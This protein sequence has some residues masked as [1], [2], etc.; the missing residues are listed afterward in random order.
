MFSGFKEWNSSQIRGEKVI[1]SATGQGAVDEKKTAIAFLRSVVTALKGLGVAEVA[2]GFDSVAS[3]ASSSAEHSAASVAAEPVV[4]ADDL[5][6]KRVS[7]LGKDF[8]AAMSGER[9]TDFKS[10]KDSCTRLMLFTKKCAALEQEITSS[11]LSTQL[12]I[13]RRKV[14]NDVG[15]AKEVLSQKVT[16]YIGRLVHHRDPNLEEMKALR[17]L[18]GTIQ[19]VL[20]DSIGG[21]IKIPDMVLEPL[22]TL[23][24][25]GVI[26][27]VERKW[28][29]ITVE[30]EQLE[31]TIATF[32][33]IPS[34]AGTLAGKIR[35]FDSKK[36]EF[37]TTVDS[38]TAKVLDEFNRLHDLIL[39]ADDRGVD[40]LKSK[41]EHL[42]QKC[43]YLPARLAAL[44]IFMSKAL[45]DMT[46]AALRRPL[47]AAAVNESQMVLRRTDSERHFNAL[48]L[49]TGGSPRS[50]EDAFL[51]ARLLADT[52]RDGKLVL[53]E[54]LGKF[55]AQLN[56]PR[57]ERLLT[58]LDINGFSFTPPQLRALLSRF[59]EGLGAIP[60]AANQAY[61]EFLALP[62][63]RQARLLMGTMEH[64][65][66][67][68]LGGQ[69]SEGHGPLM[70]EDSGGP[71]E[72]LEES[73]IG[74]AAPIVP[75]TPAAENRVE[76][77]A[78]PLSDRG[79]E[80]ASS[81]L[82]YAES[83]PPRIVKLEP[84]RMT[85]AVPIMGA[86]DI[87]G[88]RVGSGAAVQVEGDSDEEVDPQLA[89]AK[90]RLASLFAVD[91]EQLQKMKLEDFGAGEADNRIAKNLEVRQKA[92]SAIIPIEAELAAELSTATIAELKKMNTDL[93]ILDSALTQDMRDLS[94]DNRA[95]YQTLK[96]NVGIQTRLLI[97]TLTSLLKLADPRTF[98]KSVHT[99][100]ESGQLGAY[101][102]IAEGRERLVAKQAL[103]ERFTAES[104]RFGI[105][106]DAGVAEA[107][108]ELGTGIA[109]SATYLT[110]HEEKVNTINAK[111]A[112]IEAIV[113]NA[114]PQSLEAL[115]EQKAALGPL[116]TLQ[117]T[118]IPQQD[119]KAI[120][121]RLA[122]LKPGV[123]ARLAGLTKAID[124]HTGLQD[125]V[126]A[127][128]KR[129]ENLKRDVTA[130]PAGYKTALLT[131]Q[132]AG[133]A[134]SS[135]EI[136]AQRSRNSDPGLAS[137]FDSLNG[138]MTAHLAVIDGALIEQHD[139]AVLNGED[140]RASLN[141]HSQALAGIRE[142]VDN[143]TTHVELNRA[144]GALQDLG[145]ALGD[146][147]RGEMDDHA[148]L[149]LS[150]RHQVLRA[151]ITDLQDYIH[152]LVN[153]DALV[154][155]QDAQTIR[156]SDITASVGEG[157]SH[158]DLEAAR[159]LLAALDG[160]VGAV[161]VPTPGLSEA[162]SKALRSADQ[163]LRDQITT[164]KADIAR[165][166]GDGI[167]AQL[168]THTATMDRL[169]G[170][171]QGVPSREEV[172][173]SIGALAALTHELGGL[174]MRAMSRPVATEVTQRRD[175]LLGRATALKPTIS[176]L[177]GADVR[178]LQEAQTDLL[179]ALSGRVEGDLSSVQLEEK[180]VA[181]RGIAATVAGLTAPLTA[182]DI[183][184][185]TLTSG[186]ATLTETIATLA[187]RIDARNGAAVRAIQAQN[188]A[189]LERI[190][191][192]VHSTHQDLEAAQQGLADLRPRVGVFDGAG[193]SPTVAG[194]L[195]AAHGTLLGDIERQ[196]AA[197]AL[198]DG[199][200]TR[201]AFADHNG[202]LDAIRDAIADNPTHD[203]LAEQLATLNGDELAA[204]DPADMSAAVA[205]PDDL[206]GEHTRI[207]ERITTL[208]AQ[209]GQ[210]D[211][212]TARGTLE[213]QAAN[214]TT[215]NAL[216]LQ[217]VLSE[218]EAA[219]ARETLAAVEASLGV[220]NF[221]GVST[222]VS[223][224]L[225]HTKAE[226]SAQ[227]TMLGAC[228]TIREGHHVLSEE[229]AE[230]M[231]TINAD[232]SH[233]GLGEQRGRLADLE[234]R[235]AAAVNPA[236]VS[237]DLAGVL[238]RSRAA[239][240]GLISDLD[241]R[242]EVRDGTAA[243]GAQ[244]GQRADLTRLEA[245][246]TNQLDSD[247]LNVH[248]GV[249][250][251]LAGQ[252][253][254]VDL[255]AVSHAVNLELT[256]VKT[257]L[258][259]Q[260]AQIR[261]NIAA[262]N[263]DTTREAQGEQARQLA[264]LERATVVDDG[265]AG[266]NLDHAGWDVTRGTLSDLNTS[267]ATFD[268]AG[269]STPV[270]DEL[271]ATK[272]GYAARAGEVGRVIALRDGTKMRAL[273][274]GYGSEL[275]K[276]VRHDN[277]PKEIRARQ[278]RLDL[279]RDNMPFINDDMSHL[280]AEELGR[281]SAGINARA[282]DVAAD[283]RVR[284]ASSIDQILTDHTAALKKIE[285]DVSGDNL[286]GLNKGINELTDLSKTVGVFDG[287]GLAT[288]DNANLAERHSEL[289]REIEALKQS[290]AG[291]LTEL[292]RTTLE[293][294]MDTVT[295]FAAQVGE[296]PRPEALL[297]LQTVGLPN[298]R[299][300]LA[301]VNAVL[302]NTADEAGLQDQSDEIEARLARLE[303][304]I[305]RGVLGMSHAA[306][307]DGQIK[308]TFEGIVQLFNATFRQDLL[309]D[310][311]ALPLAGIDLMIRH[312]DEVID[313]A[314]QGELMAG[315]ASAKELLTSALV[316]L[317]AVKSEI[318]S[319]DDG[320][321]PNPEILFRQ[322]R[323]ALENT[324]KALL[325]NCSILEAMNRPVGG[326]GRTA[327]VAVPGERA[328]KI[329]SFIEILWSEGILAMVGNDLYD[330]A[331]SARAASSLEDIG[332]T[333][334]LLED[335]R[336]AVLAGRDAVEALMARDDVR[337]F[338]GNVRGNTLHRS[339]L[340][341]YL[342][343][344]ISAAP[345]LFGD[346]KEICKRLYSD[347]DARLEAQ[348]KAR[349]AIDAAQASIDN[350]ELE[351]RAR[352]IEADIKRHLG[353]EPGASAR[354]SELRG[355]HINTF[356]DDDAFPEMKTYKESLAA[357]GLDPDERAK[358]EKI[359]SDRRN[360]LVALVTAARNRALDGH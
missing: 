33:E 231:A 228:I 99:Q 355:R 296:Y 227:M 83:D 172:A 286:A 259:V 87:S 184:T 10:F 79:L 111:L 239:I 133:L 330:A 61:S 16:S 69:S 322:L 62:Q 113:A 164:C 152:G 31:A 163:A 110:E 53:C 148:A 180:R 92:Y 298:L 171:F 96:D 125:Q 264:A 340:A 137:Y 63:D 165:L 281:E 115:T 242:I 48:S 128:G 25:K 84:D 225:T 211:G 14:R 290:V 60:A 277:S 78:Q 261:A 136:S 100:G 168:E 11:P 22:F 208:R 354:A 271:T 307:D 229:I 334:P 65:S 7:Q 302:A 106:R 56:T 40:R 151:D 186:R 118:D 126:T 205:G 310:G 212:T 349:A 75:H 178:Q 346:S 145:A 166:N 351:L 209:I 315:H 204:F 201:V 38:L 104:V 280:V 29:G 357:A 244:D 202:R 222:A 348:Q 360:R 161:F 249:L 308:G 335:L 67:N 282:T 135:T 142:G 262:L 144:S 237:D 141:G 341:V 188:R 41:R 314:Q 157:T 49:F 195:G 200:T 123:T 98:K 214:L 6:E 289:L 220:L 35:Q 238:D 313:R 321:R 24:A 304:K 134:Q 297:N 218:A 268:S 159:Q 139:L 267:I 15:K 223:P 233:E 57:P 179:A 217:A 160:E 336:T 156:L 8:E 251:T 88:S 162:A 312:L 316:F 85:R 337:S 4:R 323:V 252:I 117:G 358:I 121:G 285:Q 332:G 318:N 37:Q 342:A 311:V 109:F 215:A 102:S 59:G 278:S 320:S 94:E 19:P 45:V 131:A 353:E 196:I 36:V 317:G 30:V 91:P 105:E 154:A 153:G 42:F 219:G 255:S 185:A 356:V 175:L 275:D 127:M 93:L 210:L 103:L 183:V 246:V 130:A 256:Q 327:A 122:K 287:A 206:G 350:E 50:R 17:Q 199:A 221:A 20:E 97:K 176:R 325:M 43:Q 235:L 181:L 192:D 140:V 299:A 64:F 270:R 54:M 27:D 288:A 146:F 305:H 232:I 295:S 74:P 77:L 203:V 26:A 338:V 240:R 207:G 81:L 331:R 5:I 39:P 213:A 28:G 324:N 292:A 247:A 129:I 250:D 86:Q 119:K 258:G 339:N 236:P 76:V 352:K 248:R 226:L 52:S 265:G 224:A 359:I 70:L 72:I 177:N 44:N 149:E 190:V 347:I 143:T 101:Q 291:K 173:Q 13:S 293:S 46:A 345:V 150:E 269:M 51:M 34:E 147:E 243:R 300:K 309:S 245:A 216:A 187:A 263:G 257:D 230:R 120:T 197:V 303:P 58:I 301:E 167:R 89:S 112:S 95:G 273:L 55:L 107:L 234:R 254:E 329:N 344:Q 18:I 158:T 82:T 294:H 253:T 138:M 108:Q 194:E 73:E 21:S 169:N 9:V 198:L 272:E 23:E 279:L 116:P 1:S 283:L 326:V 2:E 328:P 12:R 80:G 124:R 284:L 319:P 333:A 170:V 132:K 155:T 114:I 266:E 276:I 191:I 3:S 189:T 343:H 193:M 68:V 182:N 90:D 306:W 32:C 66:G 47:P 274:E 71:I 174:D 260:V 241:A